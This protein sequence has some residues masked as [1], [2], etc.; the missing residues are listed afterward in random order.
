MSTSRPLLQ[1]IAFRTAIV[2][3]V[4]YVLLNLGIAIRKNY[5]I[6]LAIRTL[7][8]DIAML[9]TRIT[10]L[11]AKLIYL[12][13]ISYRELE[14]KRRLGL[15]KT[16]EQIVLVPANSTDQPQSPTDGPT[17]TVDQTDTT[18]RSFF[19]RASESATTWVIWFAHR[20]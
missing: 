9:Q 13:S 11:H 3:A 5:T 6:N 2:L 17:L 15:K 4:A 20:D 16:G 10:F 14:A 19:E 12:Q 18:S 1:T 8:A 7:K